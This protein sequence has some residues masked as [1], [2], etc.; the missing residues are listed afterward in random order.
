MVSGPP[1][2]RGGISFFDVLDSV[3][4]KR[5]QFGAQ[6]NELT[7]EA[8]DTVVSLKDGDRV[9]ITGRLGLNRSNAIVGWVTVTPEI[10][11][12][13]GTMSL[14]TAAPEQDA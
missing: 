14:A 3:S 5:L 6:K 1:R 7:Q 8:F 12:V 10:K 2:G 11:D 4:L 9:T 13:T